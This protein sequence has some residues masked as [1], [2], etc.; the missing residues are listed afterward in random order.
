MQLFCVRQVYYEIDNIGALFLRRGLGR[1]AGGGTSLYKPYRYVRAA[2]KDMAFEPFWSKIGYRF[3]PF[4]S[5][6]G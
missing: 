1:E 5:K 3:W 2:P 6:I 4:S